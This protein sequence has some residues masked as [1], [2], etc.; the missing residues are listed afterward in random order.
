[1]PIGLIGPN[2]L[3][4]AC[5]G[6]ALGTIG[7]W[8]FPE[9]A[10]SRSFYVMLGMGAVMGAAL[11]APLAALMALVELTHNPNII[12][13]GMLA[14]TSGCL[15][16]SELFKQKSAHQTVLSAYKQMLR[17]DPLTLSHARTSVASLMLRNFQIIN[18]LLPRDGIQTLLDNPPQWLVIESAQGRKLMEW[19]H[20]KP[21]LE[22]TLA[23]PSD[24]PIDLMEHDRHILDV[25]EIPMQ[26]TLSE[27]LEAMDTH[28]VVAVFISGTHQP[29]SY[30]DLGIL[31]RREIEG[32]YHSPR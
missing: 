22:T 4:G 16:T 26:A 20:L 9:L 10:S 23:V 27:A 24:T 12:F 18:G 6:G 17:T 1:M 28:N 21:I 7:Q 3:I 8:L 14:I 15:T 13:P 5:L 29:G 25:A 11:N 31:T 32:F 2:L 19:Q 30:P